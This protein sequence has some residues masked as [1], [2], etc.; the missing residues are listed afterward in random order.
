MTLERLQK[1]NYPAVLKL[2]NGSDYVYAVI[3][4][5]DER[6]QLVIGRQ[7]FEVSRDWL[8]NYWNGGVTLLWKAP[9]S[10]DETLK[11]GQE[12]QQVAWLNQQMSEIYE[13]PQVSN[14]RFDFQLLQL[15]KTFQRDNGLDDDGVVGV[16]TL[17]PLMQ[18][19][20]PE[21]PRLYKKEH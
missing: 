7:T 15:V 20:H 17:M 18:H 6:Y 14:L 2:E 4:R 16:R 21:L 13:L 1:L 11:F 10:L 12:S 5:V 3:Y 9:F 19:M 8:L